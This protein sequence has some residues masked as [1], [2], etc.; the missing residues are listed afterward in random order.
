[1]GLSWP[2]WDGWDE[3]DLGFAACKEAEAP[4]ASAAGREEG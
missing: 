3:Q 1:V 4:A 2:G